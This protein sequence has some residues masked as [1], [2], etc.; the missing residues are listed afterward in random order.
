MSR[1]NI[2]LAALLWFVIALLVLYPLSILV[3]ESFKIAGTDNW[4]IGNYLEF[5][6]DTYYLKCFWNTLFL[7]TL[8]FWRDTDTGARLFS[9]P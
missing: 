2:S 3:L 6:Q 8:A 7:S 4:G 5:F 1:G 9:L